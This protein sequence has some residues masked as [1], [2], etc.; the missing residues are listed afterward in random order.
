MKKGITLSVA[1]VVLSAPSIHTQAADIGNGLDLSGN[2]AIASNYIWR[3][4]TQTGNEEAIQGGLDLAHE[5]GLYIGT[6]ASNISGGSEFDYY[7]GYA[8][9]LAGIGFDLGVIA[10]R[11]PQSSSS[12]FEETY[13][14]VS[15]TFGSVDTGVTFYSGH[16]SSPDAWD[17]S[18]GTD[19]GGIGATLGYTDYDS[20]SSTNYGETVSFGLSKELLSKSWPVEISLTYTDFDSDGGSSSDEEDVTISIAKSF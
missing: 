4:Q 19:L 10:Y 17:L 1:V 16:D 5:S 3:G 9:E 13:L 12:N 7:G 2:L 6:W 15:K 18:L 11:Y 14:G 20:T 8:A